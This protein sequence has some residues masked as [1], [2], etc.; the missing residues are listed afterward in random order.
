MH[1]WRTWLIWWRTTESIWNRC[2]K[3]RAWTWLMS[4]STTSLRW[5]TPTWSNR[6]V[7]CSQ[8]TPILSIKFPMLAVYPVQLLLLR[9]D[10]RH[11]RK[12]QSFSQAQRHQWRL[13]GWEAWLIWWTVQWCNKW[14]KI[15][16][17]WSKLQ[18]WWAV[19]VAQIPPTCKIWCRTHHFKVCFKIQTSSKILLACLKTL[20]I[21][22]C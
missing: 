3:L 8:I 12:S 14:C 6:Q 18:L 19:Q 5:W 21:K 4:S 13:Q 7:R 17:L 20:A 1:S 15:L 11:S 2:I 10:R 22:P 16:I 9:H